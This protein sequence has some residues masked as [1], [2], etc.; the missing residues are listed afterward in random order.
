VIGL[1]TREGVEELFRSTGGVEVTI[2]SGVAAERTWG[3]FEVVPEIELDGAAILDDVPT[4]MVWARVPGIRM[5]ALV[6]IE[7]EGEFRV[8]R[9]LPGKSPGE[10]L[11]VLSEA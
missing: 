1:D 5:E 10:T 3:H 9:R 7:G 8:S 2:G 4:L 6:T 11:L